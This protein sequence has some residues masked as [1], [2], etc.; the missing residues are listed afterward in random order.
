MAVFGIACKKSL[1]H[2]KV[3]DICISNTDDLKPANSALSLQ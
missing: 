1:T 2:T 3:L